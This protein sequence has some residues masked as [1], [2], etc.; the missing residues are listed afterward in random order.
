MDLGAR[1]CSCTSRCSSVAVLSF[2]K[3]DVAVVAAE[4][5]HDRLVVG[6][7][8]RADGPAGRAVELGQA[9]VGRH[10]DRPG[11]RHAGRVRDAAVPVLRQAAVSFLLVLPIA[12]PGI[13]T[14]DRAAEHV[15]P[16]DRPR[17]V[18]LPGRV[19]IPLARHRP[20]HVLHRR[21]LQQRG[22]PAAPLVAEPARSVG[23][24]R[25]PRLPDVPLRHV[26]ARALGAAVGRDPARSR[27][28][29]TR[30]SSP[31]S[32]PG[33]ATR[34]CRSGSSP[35]SAAPTTSPLVNV[36]ATFVM[37]VSIPLAWLAQRLADA[38]QRLSARTGSDPVRTS[39][40]GQGWSA[41]RR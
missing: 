36:V 5:V 24:P 15:R 29:S 25:R 6:R 17:A 27:S 38:D 12:L 11:A 30:S 13:V 3:A 32:P 37:I 35:T 23:R 22:R 21:R 14:G 26:P 9:G 7:R 31:R 20:R 19:R 4:G 18:R 40:D 2:N 10:A 8:W 1:S 33:R 41:Q 16:H 34:R 28:A 39:S